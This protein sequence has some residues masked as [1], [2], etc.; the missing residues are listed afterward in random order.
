MTNADHFFQ[1][2]YSCMANQTSDV[3]F[4]ELVLGLELNFIFMVFIA[5]YCQNWS[6]VTSEDVIIYLLQH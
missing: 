6:L 2:V 3:C 1:C 5:T 4:M